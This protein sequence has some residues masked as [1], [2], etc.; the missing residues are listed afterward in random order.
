MAISSD[1]PEISAAFGGAQQAQAAISHDDPEIAA[2]FAPA[3]PAEETEL[4]KATRRGH[5]ES[6][7][8]QLA[9]ELT[10]GVLHS[11]SGGA[12]GAYTLLTTGDSDKA[13]DAVNTETAKTY[14]APPSV[15]KDIVSSK[16]NPVNWPQAAASSIAES[17]SDNRHLIDPETSVDLGPSKPVSPLAATAMESFPTAAGAALGVRNLM[18]TPTGAAVDAQSV[19]NRASEGQSMGAAGVAPD[20]SS[21][22]PEIKA[23]ITNTAPENLNAQA[24]E[25][26][27]K[28]DK[29]GV[30][31]TRGMATQD[32]GEWTAEYNSRKAGDEYSA[33]T[34]KNNKALISGLDD[35]RR[36]ASPSRVSPDVTAN[37]QALVDLEK[38]YA[39]P[40]VQAIRDAYK[41]LTDA[42]G[43]KFPVDGKQLAAN[44]QDG[45]D[46]ALKSG[47]APMLEKQIA[48]FADG[49]RQMTFQDYEA[50]RTDSAAVMR[51]ADP[52]AAQ[53]AKVVR[54]KL[55][56]LPL[57]GETATKLKPL[58][59]KA[60]KLAS[61]WHDELESNPSLEEAVN[62]YNGN[63]PV[64]QGQKSTL[65]EDFVQK[66]LINGS[67]ADL[68]RLQQRFAGNDD[69]QEVIQAAPLNY[70]KKRAG[71]DAYDNSGD[72]RQQ[73]YNSAVNELRPNMPYLLRPETA[74]KVSDLGE[75]ARLAKK[76]PE[77]A[78]P[79]RSGS[80][81]ELIRDNAVS[82]GKGALQTALDTK[83]LGLTH[84]LVGRMF[85]DK[86]HAKFVER[87]FKPGAGINKAD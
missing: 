21:V 27:A 67:Q 44:V 80:A 75:V 47:Y 55:E 20:I 59:D 76:Q 43:G 81:I 4:S 1:D 56:E 84:G 19:V 30:Q 61:D 6:S 46:H 77:G 18:R 35:I 68:E 42:N 53:A 29:F 40:K 45:L 2:A 23:E 87:N 66:H 15:L 13:A 39:A 79:N 22:S 63:K 7:A 78:V 85:P 12:K 52:L 48:Q 34:D 57:T 8:A 3:D 28:A 37:G 64:K 36:E 11:V 10:S 16:Y 62:D 17:A 24:L 25:N 71:I 38:Q 31:L 74:Q 9:H 41:E 32:P 73:A 26:H 72:F 60:R 69:A 58:A 49:R 50:L 86:T 70:I 65:A 82:G 5:E 51:G 14:R 54:S 33:I 83:T